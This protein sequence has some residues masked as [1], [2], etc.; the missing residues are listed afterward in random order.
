MWETAKVPGSGVE[1]NRLHMRSFSS[2]EW[3]LHVIG[4]DVQEDIP[5]W[6]TARLQGRGVNNN[7]LQTPIV[8]PI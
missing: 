8:K 2:H 5:V 4:L 3:A 1:N 7:S 6:E